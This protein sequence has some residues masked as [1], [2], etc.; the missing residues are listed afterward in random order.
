MLRWYVV[1]TAVGR[2]QKVSRDLRERL[3]GALESGHAG[4]IIV[5]VETFTQQVGGKNVTKQRQLMPGYLLLQAD[6]LRVRGVVSST[7]GVMEILGGDRPQPLSHEEADRMLGR[8][9]STAPMNS[10]PTF[11]VGQIVSIV[12]GPFSGFD[13]E[14]IECDDHNR[15]VVVE[16]EIFGRSTP[17]TVS[18]HQIQ[19]AGR[20]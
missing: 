15:T 13:G 8:A 11:T 2:E 16:L 14:V 1:R 6:I 9:T 20:R 12:E 18:H 4:E 3:A 7:K 10:G 5:P 19:G 17:A